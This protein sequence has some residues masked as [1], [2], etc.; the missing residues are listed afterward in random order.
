MKRKDHM[1]TEEQC[2]F[3]YL[4]WFKLSV[5]YMCL[6]PVSTL[7]LLILVP[8]TKVMSVFFMGRLP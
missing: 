3:E 5:N 8:L 1:L 6:V 4:H 7:F 2:R